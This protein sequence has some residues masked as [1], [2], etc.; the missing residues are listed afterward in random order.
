MNNESNHDNE[1]EK[2]ETQCVECQRELHL[3]NECLRIHV[4]VIGS[5]GFV[6]L[7][8]PTCV[9]DHDCARRYFGPEEE[10]E[11]LPRRVP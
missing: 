8:E 5:R 10:A 7:R 4:G 2:Q 3:G 1:E 9:C 11:R 6:P